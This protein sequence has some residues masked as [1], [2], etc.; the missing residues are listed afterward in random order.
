MPPISLNY[1]FRPDLLLKV[2]YHSAS[3]QFPLGVPDSQM[4]VGSD[5]VDVEWA[6]AGLSVSF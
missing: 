1:R 2:E 3:T 5:P 4:G 6:I